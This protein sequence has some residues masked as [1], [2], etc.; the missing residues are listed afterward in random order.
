MCP[1]WGIAFHKKPEHSP[2]LVK[3][4]MTWQISRKFPD[5]RKL[6]VKVT[7]MADIKYDIDVLLFCVSTGHGFIHVLQIYGWY[8]HWCSRLCLP[9]TNV[10]LRTCNYVSVIQEVGC[11]PTCT[12]SLAGFSLHLKLAVITASAN[13]F[14]PSNALY[15]QFITSWQGKNPRYGQFLPLQVPSGESLKKT[16]LSG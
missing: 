15:M 10:I 9:V 13:H 2:F 14:T 11:A 16:L 4:E 8:S 6:Q 5:F 12:F 1:G 3:S 7:D